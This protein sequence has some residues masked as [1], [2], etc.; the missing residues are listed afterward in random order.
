MNNKKRYIGFTLISIVYVIS[1]IVSVL[2][3]SSVISLIIN[4]LFTSLMYGIILHTMR[5]LRRFMTIMSDLEKGAEYLKTINDSNKLKIE[6]VFPD[7]V[8][9]SSLLNAYFKENSG[10]DGDIA[11]YINERILDEI[12]HKQTTELA[13]SAM[14]G[15]GLLGT[16][17]GLILGIKDLDINQEQL[18]E[19]IKTLM[20]GMKTAFLTSIFGV[21]YSL[22]LNAL[23][24]RLY[25]DGLKALD[26]FYETFYEKIASNPDN[27]NMHLL[28]NYQ[29][30][31]VRG[32]E[33]LP[34]AISTAITEQIDKV[35]TPTITKM[36]HL[37]EQFV[38]VAT[39][40]QQKSLEIL[41]HS[42]VDSMNSI[43]NEKFVMLADTLDKTCEMQTQNY[44]MM[45]NVV[46]AT[47][48]QLQHLSELNISVEKA[49]TNIQ[50]Y[51]VAIEN[52]N[53]SI[54]ANNTETHNLIHSVLEAQN[55]TAI[56]IQELA[57]NLTD[58][59]SY[60]VIVKDF[61][62]ELQGIIASFSKQSLEM[63]NTNAAV[64][65]HANQNTEQI[66]NQYCTETMKAVD[67]LDKQIG[68][69]TTISGNLITEIKTVGSRIHTEC[70]GL[71]NSLSTSLNS[72]FKV[73]DE[74][75]AEITT[76][77]NSS[78]KEMQELID[79]IPR[80]LYITI[81]KLKESMD[82]CVLLLNDN[83]TTKEG[84]KV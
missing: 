13:V 68:A 16:F 84:N 44:E 18:M 8:E 5:H 62:K 9:L 51:I 59:N 76:H 7:N 27:R 1:I 73:F 34:I 36:D 4:I 10:F 2:L 71:E 57:K 54:A 39:S 78:I 38:S 80:D 50:K 69:F 70:N 63:I 83:N 22:L 12:I 48:A 55:N 65:N 72:T 53:S 3:R 35:F 33:N 17:V 26:S 19:S 74:N 66:V 49:L 20:N 31:L 32:F 25:S 56:S 15:L 40:N 75:L 14:T 61:I 42:F 45:N 60:V 67:A 52:F 23:Y 37:M 11:N 29:E 58:A 30:Q 77:L 79:R 6:S 41:V 47:S 81:G 24:K 43:L 64:I 46:A 21:T 82:Q 28:L